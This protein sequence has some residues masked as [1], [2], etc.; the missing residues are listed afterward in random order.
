MV[1]QKLVTS[2]HSLIA[3]LQNFKECHSKRKLGISDEVLSADVVRAVTQELAVITLVNIGSI[4]QSKTSNN[5]A[6][7]LFN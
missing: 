4:C 1:K 3:G 6:P 2:A 5:L 7:V